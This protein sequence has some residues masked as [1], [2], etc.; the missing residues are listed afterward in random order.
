[1]AK[2]LPAILTFLALSAA[3]GPLMAQEFTQG[4][5][6]SGMG[7]AYTG[8]AAG[9]SGLYFNPGGIASSMMY[10]VE[11]AYEFT[12]TGSVLNATII[13]SK[14]N[15]DVAAGVGYSY[16]FGREGA[17]DLTG[18]DI[19]LGIALPVLPQRISV[20]VGGRYILVNEDTPDGSESLMKGFTLDAGALFRASDMVEI[21][22]AG[23]NLLNICAKNKPCSTVAPTT[24][25]GGLSFSDQETYVLAADGGIDLNSDP[26]GVNPFFQVGAEYFAGE[27]VPLRLGYQRLW[28]GSRNMLTAGLGMR[29]KSAGLDAGFRMD[30]S[31]TDY[32]FV[33]GS[34]SLFF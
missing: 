31:D 21:G 24:I 27:A 12:P 5:R 4:V 6:P 15:P 26:D 32:Y 33:N 30:L 18:H 13:D 29:L 16:F 17:E 9:T 34:F 11:G 14:T 20:G 7:M 1:M 19:R 23:R 2:R 3:A 25:A 22:V 8:V 10:Q 28:F